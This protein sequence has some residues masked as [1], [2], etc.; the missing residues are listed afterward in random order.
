MADLSDFFAA[1]EDLQRGPVSMVDRALAEM[2]EGR[3]EQTLAALHSRDVTVRA[4]VKV[5]S[6]WGHQI[7]TNSVQHWRERHT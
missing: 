5:L 4:I 6:D 2:D 1:Q 3:R 7:S